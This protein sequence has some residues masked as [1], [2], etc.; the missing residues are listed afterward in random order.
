MFPSKD[1]KYMTMKPII[2]KAIQNLIKFK[3][4]TKGIYS[5]QNDSKP[6]IGLNFL[7]TNYSGNKYILCCMKMLKTTS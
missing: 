1:Y 4:S 7:N 5:V 2:S 6:N 3:K